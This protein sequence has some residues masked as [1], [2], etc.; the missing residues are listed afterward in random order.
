MALVSVAA[1]EVSSQAPKTIWDGV[2]TT[3]QAMRGAE[4][5]VSHCR[6]CHG[7][8][9]EGGIDPADEEPAPALRGDRAIESLKRRRDLGNLFDYISGSM[10]RDMAGTLGRAAYV[11]V[12]AY[13]LQQYGM[14]AGQAPLRADGDVLGTILLTRE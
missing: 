7:M 1:V 11:D 2:F 9:L 13:L 3:G 6:S 14:P 4:L 12:V 8:D 10:P 5:Y